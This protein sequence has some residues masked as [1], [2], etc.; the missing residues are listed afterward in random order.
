MKKILTKKIEASRKNPLANYKL[1][2]QHK[3]MLVEKKI[4]DT[5][6]K[7]DFRESKWG[8]NGETRIDFYQE[9]GNFP[10]SKLIDNASNR[11]LI[12]S[13]K[14]TSLQIF[15]FMLFNL[16]FR[17]DEAEINFTKCIKQKLNI[18]KSSFLSAIEELER[19][20]IIR[21]IGIKRTK[22]YWKFFIN[23]QLMFKGDAKK[24]Y[25]DVLEMYPHYH[26]P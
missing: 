24:Y 2:I 16:Y 4:K 8:V 18:S 15:V 26:Q 11:D 9:M 5:S 25:Q 10:H 6:F 17:T 7:D 12:F 22:D 14:S 20:G 1:Q 13:L 21:R 3:K 19:K 23:P